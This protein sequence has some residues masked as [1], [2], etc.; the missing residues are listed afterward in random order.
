MKRII[1]I[2]VFLGLFFLLA[3]QGFLKRNQDSTQMKF[4]EATLYF[5]SGRIKKIIL[6]KD[7]TIQGI[8]F[9]EDSIIEFYESS[10]KI[11]WVHLSRECNIQGINLPGGTQII[12]YESGK[13]AWVVLPQDW[14]IRGESYKAGEGVYF[15]KTGKII[16]TSRGL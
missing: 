15:D 5:N 4:T 14:K 9:P 6:H 1:L 13:I 11:S 16:K 2:W 8:C 7:Y 3:I 12:F 10:G